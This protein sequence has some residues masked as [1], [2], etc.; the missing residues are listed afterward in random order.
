MRKTPSARRCESTQAARADRGRR[1]PPVQSAEERPG[2][3][4]VVGPGQQHPRPERGILRRADPRHAAGLAV[5][6]QRVEPRQRA[7]AR[8]VDLRV[9]AGVDRIPGLSVHHPFTAPAVMPAITRRCATRKNSVTGI[10]V[11]TDMAMIPWKL[12]P[13]SPLRLSSA[14]GSV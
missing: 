10:V 11:S 7:A 13:S 12:T 14:T 5:G 8:R 4:G 3:H 2:Q 6:L 1:V 9:Q